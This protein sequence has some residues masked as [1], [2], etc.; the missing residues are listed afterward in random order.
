MNFA[1]F[2]YHS[3]LHQLARLRRNRVT[4]ENV[5]ANLL[6]TRIDC[7]GCGGGCCFRELVDK[8]AH[9]YASFACDSCEAISVLRDDGV[10]IRPAPV[11]R[12][13]LLL[14]PGK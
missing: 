2:E 13:P 10:R 4:A 7:E 14:S 1:Q 3:I 5:R 9:W 12:E 8:G 6:G 11:P